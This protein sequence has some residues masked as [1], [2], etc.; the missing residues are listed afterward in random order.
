MRRPVIVAVVWAT[1]N[2]CFR[3]FVVAILASNTN[4]KLN[5]LQ[6]YE[7]GHLPSTEPRGLIPVPLCPIDCNH[8]NCPHLNLLFI[9]IGRKQL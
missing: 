2:F 1:N 5:H 6:A 7:L 8:A 4:V 9:D 3:R